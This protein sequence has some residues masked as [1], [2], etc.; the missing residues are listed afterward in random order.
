MSNQ[1][2]KSF[3]RV[4]MESLA[5][6]DNRKS[7]EDELH[8]YFEDTYGGWDWCDIYREALKVW[9][10]MFDE[11]IEDSSAVAAIFAAVAAQSAY[12]AFAA[13]AAAIGL[14]AKGLEAA[15]SDWYENQDD[16]P[17]PVSCE[18]LNE[19][20]KEETRQ[21]NDIEARQALIYKHKQLINAK[22]N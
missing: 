8:Y 10:V 11:E 13:V 5:D 2:D 21:L 17:K 20:V 7:I 1:N 22:A 9:K 14:D 16:L 12:G 3:R 18:E 15:V 19:K 6:W 4:T